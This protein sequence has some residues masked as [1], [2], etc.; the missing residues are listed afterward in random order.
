MKVTLDNLYRIAYQ[1]EEDAEIPKD[2]KNRLQ[3]LIKN[4]NLTQREVDVLRLRWGEIKTLE[5]IGKQIGISRSRVSQIETSAIRKLIR[6][7]NIQ[8]NKQE[9]DLDSD[10]STLGISVHT[11]NCLKRGGVSTIRELCSRS[12]NDLLE[13]RNLGKETLSEIKQVLTQYGLSLSSKPASLSRREHILYTSILFRYLFNI[14]GSVFGM[15][16]DNLVKQVMYFSNLNEIELKILQLR[17]YNSYTFEDVSNTL[18]IEKEQ[19]IQIEEG[20]INKMAVVASQFNSN[21][22]YD[23]PLKNLGLSRRV[24]IGLKRAGIS[25][26]RELCNYTS[27]DILKIRA[28]GKKALE[29]IEYVVSKYGFGLRRK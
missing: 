23:I 5:A 24:Y 16:Y 19:V 1:C 20:A 2:Y 14:E 21:N 6:R 12:E 27:S 17:L 3:E 10:I 11:Y 7:V 28:L 29:E 26:L 25:T 15:D 13:I 22:S 4:A 9:F 18:G 8:S